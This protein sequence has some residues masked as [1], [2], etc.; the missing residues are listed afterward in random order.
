MRNMVLQLRDTVE[1]QQ[2]EIDEQHVVIREAGLAVEEQSGSSLS[3]FLETT[4]FSGSVAASYFYNTNDPGSGG[5]GNTWTPGAAVSNPF[6]PDHNSI[7]FDELWLS[8][9]RGATEERRVGFGF[10]VVWGALGDINGNAPGGGNSVWIP[11]AYI[12]YLSPFG[13]TLTAGKFGTHIGYEVA[14][15]A[16]NATITRGFTYQSF[17]PVSQI[18]ARLSGDAGPVSWMV[19]VVNGL[20][21]NQPD[22]DGKKDVIWSLGWGTDVISLNFA[23]EYGGDAEFFGGTRGENALVLDGI[24]EL[25]PS[26]AVVAWLDVTWAKVFQ[27]GTRD[28]NGLGVNLGS[29]VAVTDRLGLTGR[30][31][32]GMGEDPDI[33]GRATV[34]MPGGGRE[35]DAI[36]LTGV[37]DYLVVEGLTAKAEVKWEKILDIDLATDRIFASG[38]GLTT[39]DSQL[40]LG[41]QLV[42]AF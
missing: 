18:G 23:G 7:Q 15:A 33:A 16:Y 37:V 26:D 35:T 12:E 41:V 36:A 20:G 38:S 4:D 22:L 34:F 32:Y 24:V 14:G 2:D 9:S 39:E 3:S 29:R 27:R 21:A 11:A 5:G 31:E 1:A 13:V 19:G 40:L 28:P 17:Q 25:T 30:F 42:Y 6:H 8:A 10:D